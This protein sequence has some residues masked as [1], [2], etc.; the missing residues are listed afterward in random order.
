M[1]VTKSSNLLT[2]TKLSTKSHK[3][4]Q[5]TKHLIDKKE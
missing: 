4:R 2:K 3:L 1:A 5:P